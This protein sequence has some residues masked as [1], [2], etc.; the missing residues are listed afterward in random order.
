MFDEAR[1]QIYMTSGAAGGDKPMGK[2]AF[3][4]KL[5]FSANQR[6]NIPG[7]LNIKIKDKNMLG[8][9]LRSQDGRAGQIPDH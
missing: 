7:I 8:S 5:P 2:Y 4:N 6:S 3:K 1:G 9:F